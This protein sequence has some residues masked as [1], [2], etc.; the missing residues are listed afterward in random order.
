[1]YAVHYKNENNIKGL[2]ITKAVF[3]TRDFYKGGS[4]G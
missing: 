2:R 3:I 1:M 4:Y